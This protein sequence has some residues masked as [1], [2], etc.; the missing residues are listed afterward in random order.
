M[1]IMG[2]RIIKLR[3]EAL[4]ERIFQ[5]KESH[6]KDYEEAVRAY[7]IEAKH[8][9]A[10]VTKDLESGSLEIGFSL[11]TPVNK[12]EN[13]D[14]IAEMFKWETREEVEL[15]QHEFNEYVLDQN[16]ESVMARISN[17]SY[18]GKLIL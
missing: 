15:T 9:I 13:Y 11:I 4:I 7:K 3:K 14:Q 6:I 8:Q 16:T 17:S 18:K 1:L 12:S 2:N 10:K 5:N